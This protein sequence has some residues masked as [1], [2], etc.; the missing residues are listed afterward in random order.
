[1]SARALRLSAT[2]NTHS[3]ASTRSLMAEETCQLQLAHASGTPTHEFQIMERSLTLMFG[4]ASI[5]LAIFLRPS[6][7]CGGGEVSGHFGRAGQAGGTHALL[8]PEHGSVGL[9]DLLHLEAQVGDRAV[10]V[11][12]AHPVEV[13]E[14]R[15]AGVARQR[16][17]GLAGLEVLLDVLGL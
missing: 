14:R 12:V 13:V 16:L 4:R 6:W 8:R 3:R 7:S 5:V 9:H 15:G 10:A 17:V 2:V 11:R 1:M